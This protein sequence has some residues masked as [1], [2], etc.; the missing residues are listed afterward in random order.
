MKMA[1]AALFLSAGLM[2]S[3]AAL[4]ADAR[5]S[6]T[7]TDAGFLRLD[8]QTGQVSHCREKAGGFTCDLAADER[9]AY[10][11]E[12][13]SLTKRLERLEA[14]TPAERAGVPTEEELDEAFGFFE[15]MAKRFARAARVF[16]GEMQKMDEELNAYPD[17]DEG[18]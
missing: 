7:Q 10:E 15:S 18:T 6:M 12:I 8:T 4:A 17:S 13:A 11:S 16:G 14:R 2:I 5:Y 1:G 9:T 3:G